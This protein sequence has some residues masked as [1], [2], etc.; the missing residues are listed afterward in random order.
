MAG[1]ELYGA[2]DC[3]YTR[4]WREHLLWRGVAFAEFDVGR[5]LEARSRLAVLAMGPL[6]VPVLVEDGRIAAVGWR[7]RSCLV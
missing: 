1:L 3:P 6:T 5:D 4:E 2:A 7:G